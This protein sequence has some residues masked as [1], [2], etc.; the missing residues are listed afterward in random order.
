MVTLADARELDVEDFLGRPK[1]ETD[2]EAIADY[3]QGK[4]VLV[5]GRGVPLASSSPGRSPASGR[6][7]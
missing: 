1:V 6:S 7:S 2:L 5:T 3:L 4:R